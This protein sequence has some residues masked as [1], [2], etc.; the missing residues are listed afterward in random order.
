[1]AIES[2]ATLRSGDPEQ[3]ERT[4]AALLEELN[5]PKNQFEKLQV[6]PAATLVTAQGAVLKRLRAGRAAAP[7]GAGW[8]PVMDGKV[9]PAHPFDPG[10]PYI[11]K[12]VPLLIGSCQNEFV[13]GVDNPEVD[14]LT[15]EELL[16]RVTQKYGEASQSIVA[17]YRK[18]YPKESPFGL[19][20][21]ISA[22]QMRQNTATQAERKAAQNGAPVY[23]YIYAWRT[24]V[25]DGRP[26][27]FHSSEIA[28]VFDNADLCTRYS[29]GGTEA[30]KLSSAMGGSWAA[31]ARTGKPGHAGLPEWPAYTAEKRSTMIFNTPCTVKND[32]EGECLR[33]VP[34][35]T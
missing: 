3:A 10:A 18:E 23:Q 21:A 4:A 31:F 9:V 14:S 24:P 33:L 12:Q 25:L 32:P 5:I 17:A 22:S 35:R 30:L 11:S 1:A 26:G 15:N 34:Q 13:N 19:W 6:V 27:T 8:G 16:K 29:G 20:A 28:F 7:G 2:G